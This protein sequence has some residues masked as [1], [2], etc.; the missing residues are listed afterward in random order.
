VK[1]REWTEDGA[2]EETRGPR[3]LWEAERKDLLDQNLGERS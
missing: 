1:R 2:G 3:E